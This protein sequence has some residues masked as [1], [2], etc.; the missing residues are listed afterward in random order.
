MS[1]N[2]IQACFEE[3][4][5]CDDEHLKN[6]NKDYFKFCC[7]YVASNFSLFRLHHYQQGYVAFF[8]YTKPSSGGKIGNTGVLKMSTR[9]KFSHY[10][11]GVYG[12][13]KTPNCLTQNEIAIANWG[14]NSPG[15]GTKK[16]KAGFVNYYVMVLIPKSD[17]NLEFIK[18]RNMWVYRKDIDINNFL[19]EMGKF[20]EFYAEE[21]LKKY[22]H[23]LFD[24]SMYKK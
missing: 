20:E 19:H 6:F 14:A 24:Y 23:L 21:W 4:R 18:E 11:Y 1:K 17:K 7:T 5:E 16:M 2:V 10:G 3:I 12:T 9:K 15:T 8:H 22:G 13:H